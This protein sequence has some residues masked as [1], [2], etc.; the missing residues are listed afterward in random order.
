MPD[1]NKF[2]KLREIGYTIPL[3]CEDCSHAQFPPR[4]DWG[5]CSFHRYEHKKH[6]GPDRGISITRFGTC[7]QL[8]P[9]PKRPAG[10]YGAHEEFVRKVT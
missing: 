7:P 5:E 3:G 1:E 6:T 10:R 9:D 2:A 4:G 8:K